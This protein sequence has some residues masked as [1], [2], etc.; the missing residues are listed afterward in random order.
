M[1][2]ENSPVQSDYLS[3]YP[4]YLFYL[5]MEKKRASE[6]VFNFLRFKTTRYEEVKILTGLKL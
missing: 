1:D 3:R 6:T 2:T 4:F 5:V